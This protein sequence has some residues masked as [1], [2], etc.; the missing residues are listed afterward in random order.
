VGHWSELE[1]SLTSLH[2]AREYCQVE[3]E[4]P[5]ESGSDAVDDSWP[6]AGNISFSDVCLPASEGELRNLIAF[7]FDGHCDNTREGLW[8]ALNNVSLDIKGG[9]CCGFLSTK[10]FQGR[11][12]F[13]AALFRMTELSSGRVSIDGQDIAQLGLLRLRQAISLISHQPVLF[14]GSIRKNIDPLSLHSDEEVAE[15][16]TIAPH[17]ASTEFVSLILVRSCAC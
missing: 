16:S 13:I 4:A 2:K 6:S 3:P 12:S 17:F 7:N 11:S 14:S 1:G 15:A 8:G 10:G 9:E 5:L